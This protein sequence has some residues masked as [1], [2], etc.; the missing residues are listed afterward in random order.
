MMPSDTKESFS[1]TKP[2][3]SALIRIQLMAFG[4][5]FAA[6]GALLV[7]ITA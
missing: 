5:G 3:L 4:V 6:A 7:L 2:D 1:S